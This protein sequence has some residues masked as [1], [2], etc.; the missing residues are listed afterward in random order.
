MNFINPLLW[1]TLFFLPFF[2]DEVEGELSFESFFA[3]AGLDPLLS[4]ELKFVSEDG[5]ST[6]KVLTDFTEEWQME[7]R[8]PEEWDSSLPEE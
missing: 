8:L 3:G 5:F 6:S 7:S 1:M 2:V 4:V